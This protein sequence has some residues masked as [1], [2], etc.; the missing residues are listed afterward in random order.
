MNILVFSDSHRALS[1]MRQA[2]EL[3][4]PDSVIHLGDLERDAQLLEQEYPNLPITGVPGNCDGFV[5]TP[6]QR[7]VTYAG[8]KVLM[9]HGHIWNVKGGY[10]AA[11]YAARQCQAD[12][13][14]F[15][16]THVPH[17]EQLEDGL[18]VVNPGSIRDRGSYAVLTP[19][20]TPLCQLRRI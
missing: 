6:L 18:W 5:T 9:S 19:G 17:C 15:G 2:V 8:V 16:H 1:G 14:L 7:L 13:V 20:Q 12:V 11:I 3:E 4:R 10:R